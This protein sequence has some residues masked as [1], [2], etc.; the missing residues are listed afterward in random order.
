MNQLASLLLLASALSGNA[1]ASSKGPP[2]NTGLLQMVTYVKRNPNMTLDEFWQYWDTQHA[3]KVIPLATH[4]GIARYQQVRVSGKI[5]P[6]DAGA[7][8]PVS[9]NLVDFDGIAM[10]L[11]ESAD[12]LIDM[13]SH[14]YYVNVVE[15][16]EHVFIDKSAHG[17]GMVATYIGEHIDA[18]DD[19]KSVWKG[20]KKTLSKYQKLFK[21]Y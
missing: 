8:E 6:T 18:V 15:P 21:K 14:P 17:N 11:Y 7:T 13:L 2:S 4:F 12:V 3:P 16:D 20:D 19:A 5:V 1:A 10:F 9:N